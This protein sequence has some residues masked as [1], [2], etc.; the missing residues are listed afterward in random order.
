MKANDKGLETI[1]G[2]N[3]QE[4]GRH[5][6]SRLQILAAAVGLTVLL[7]GGATWLPQSD[8]DRSNDASAQPHA[9]VLAEP[10]T[11][12][13]PL[14]L[15]QRDTDHSSDSAAQVAPTTFVYFP[16]QYVNQGKEVELHIQAF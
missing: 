6:T 5:P 10:T 9:G 13:F 7:M 8:S 16:G 14:D 3:S 11:I 4:A 2:S 1:Q 12:D 15:A